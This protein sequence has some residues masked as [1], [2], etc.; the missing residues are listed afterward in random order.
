[1]LGLPPKAPTGP[2]VR[3]KDFD[4]VGCTGRH[5]DS[6]SPAYLLPARP[7]GG[8]FV[9]VT[10]NDAI[11]GPRAD[12]PLLPVSQAAAVKSL[13]AGTAASADIR[14]CHAAAT[15]RVGMYG[16]NVWSPG[17]LRSWFTVVEEGADQLD[18]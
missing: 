14:Y 18:C 6:A 11:S 13:G 12:G 9:E 10:V 1:M 2:L 17:L 15:E 5:C 4:E 8:G 16:G 7:A 3:Q